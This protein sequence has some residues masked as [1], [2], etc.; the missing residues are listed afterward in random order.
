VACGS[1][2]VDAAVELAT[3]F[4]RAM[5]RRRVAGLARATARPAPAAGAG[6]GRLQPLQLTNGGKR[7]A[8][9]I[10]KTPPSG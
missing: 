1:G 5:A 9:E 3:N 7:K 8:D 2:Q 10:T 6:G 4:L